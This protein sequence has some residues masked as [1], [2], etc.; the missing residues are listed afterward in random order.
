MTDTPI[1]HR[2]ARSA[3]AQLAEAPTSG[4]PRPIR[5]MWELRGWRLVLTS[6][7]L[8]LYPGKPLGHAEVL[9]LRDLINH[10]LNVIAT[11]TVA[12]PVVTETGG[13]GS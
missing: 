6:D 5:V 7:G 2:P 8:D 4:Q 11:G 3:N 12:A 1:S 10:A 13:D 9:A